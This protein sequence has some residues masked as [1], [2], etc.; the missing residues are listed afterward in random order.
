MS[1]ILIVDDETNIL[2]NLT[3]GFVREGYEVVTAIDGL[4]ALEKVRTEK[5][6]LILLDS[7]LPHMSGL[8]VLK[9]LRLNYNMPIIMLTARTHEIDKIL[10]LELGADDYITKPYS[11]REVLARCKAQLRRT[12]FVETEPQNNASVLRFDNYE[13]DFDALEVRRDGVN[14]GMTLREFDLVAFLA[15]NS[16]QVFSRE[17]L[18][19]Q[20]W[21]YDYYGD[22]RTVDVTVRRTREKLEPD[23]NKYKYIL[24]KRGVGYYFD[25]NGGH[26]ND[27][28]SN[29]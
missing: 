1:R 28:K 21:D 12:H 7:M 24:T 8:D 11:F 4:E 5:P 18:L 10:G 3:E 9:S 2:D 29:I 23:P 26:D 13:I 19:Q 20:V 27:N 14:L 6:D 25:K 22:V 17:E 15:K 16:G